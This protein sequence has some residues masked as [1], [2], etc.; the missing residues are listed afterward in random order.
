MPDKP[1]PYTIPYMHSKHFAQMV[2]VA[3]IKFN[4]KSKFLYVC[5]II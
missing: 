4:L 2:V 1:W 5:T 3:E